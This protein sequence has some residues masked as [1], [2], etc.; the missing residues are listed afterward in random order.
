MIDTPASDRIADYG[1]DEICA[2]IRDGTSLT[3]IA[4]KIG[5]SIGLLSLWLSKDVERSARAREARVLT[6]RLWDEKAESV[7][8]DATDPLSLEKGKQLAHHYRWRASKIAPGSYGDKVVQ[9]HVGRD[10]GAIETVALT[11]DQAARQ[12]RDMV[13]GG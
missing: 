13:D 7:I 2:D 1:L 6:A 5:V 4:Q 11:P 10:G 12:Y 3:V 8:N 9:E